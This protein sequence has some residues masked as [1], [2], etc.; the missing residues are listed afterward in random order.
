MRTILCTHQLPASLKILP[1]PCPQCGKGYGGCQIVLFNPKYYFY[2]T[3]YERLR[4]YV[5][6]RISH[7]YSKTEK[8]KSNTR[9]KIV[10]NFQ[11][12]VDSIHSIK[13]KYE[14][15]MIDINRIFTYAEYEYKHSITYP[16][17]NQIYEM[18]IE[19]WMACNRNSEST[20]G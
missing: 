18:Y 8:T 1:R 10:H 5:I 9:K 16:L 2:R 6:L 3:G 13:I 17:G 11:I 12:I 7:G 4:P 14:G 15:N 19:I 20:L